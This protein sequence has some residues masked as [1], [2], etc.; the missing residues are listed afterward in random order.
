MPTGNFLFPAVYALFVT[1]VLLISDN[2][3]YNINDTPLEAVM[4]NMM[5]AAKLNN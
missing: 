1:L 3:R 2:P 4:Y 5:V